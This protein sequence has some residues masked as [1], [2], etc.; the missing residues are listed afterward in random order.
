[1]ENVQGGMNAEFFPP[2]KKEPVVVSQ[3]RKRK[4]MKFAYTQKQVFVCPGRDGIYVQYR[5]LVTF[6]SSFGTGT[7][8]I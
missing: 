8:N 7:I 5:I 2:A 3:G 6:F 1:M 4:E